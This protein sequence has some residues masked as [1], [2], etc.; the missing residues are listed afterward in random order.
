M[1]A[2]GH[3]LVVDDDAAMGEV[4]VADLSRRGFTVQAVTDG[5]RALEALGGEDFDAILTD[6]NMRGMDGLELCAR[7]SSA[8]AC[9]SSC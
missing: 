3:V 2:R 9:R 1:R 6:L 7:A 5:A 8:P 4:L